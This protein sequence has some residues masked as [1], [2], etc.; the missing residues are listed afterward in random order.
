MN[1]Y[2]DEQL[3]L[4]KKSELAWYEGLRHKG[5]SGDVCELLLMNYL[6]KQF[7]NLNFGKGQI[8][9]SNAKGEKLKKEKTNLSEQI[10]IIC[11]TGKSLLDKKS[12]GNY[13]VVNKDQVKFTIEVKKWTGPADYSLEKTH[14]KNAG[15]L[16]KNLI[17][18]IDFTNKDNILVSF[19][20]HGRKNGERHDIKEA[21]QK[22][23]NKSPKLHA[24]ILSNTTT[25]C[26]IEDKTGLILKKALE[27]DQLEQ[28]INKITEIIKK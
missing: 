24:Y 21:I 3:K 6:K 14:A 12:F 27:K 9:K 18:I 28:L 4:V 13:V 26:P 23:I 8:K 16:V 19:R 22:C 5:V 15:K 10:D 17:K 11:Y 1:S 25:K 20:Y 2:N 7:P